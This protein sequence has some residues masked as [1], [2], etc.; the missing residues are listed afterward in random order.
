MSMFAYGLYSGDECVYVGISTNPTSRF[1]KHR[2]SALGNIRDLPGATMR[3]F[4]AVSFEHCGRIEAQ[5]IR[6]FWRRGQAKRNLTVSPNKTRV[7]SCGRHVR[8]VETGKIYRSRA[9]VALEFGVSPATVK[10][11]MIHWNGRVCFVNNPVFKNQHLTI[12]LTENTS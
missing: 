10:N 7:G 8:C 6:A 2:N 12:G 11:G 5:I 4:R 9:E 3:I 1:D